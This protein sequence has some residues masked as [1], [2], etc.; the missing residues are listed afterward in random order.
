MNQMLGPMTRERVDELLKAYMP[1]KHT[2]ADIECEFDAVNKP[3]AI[4]QPGD[5]ERVTTLNLKH[6][7]LTLDHLMPRPF[8]EGDI[9]VRG[10]YPA[11]TIFKLDRNDFFAGV[12]RHDNIR[13]ATEEEKAVYHS[14][15]ATA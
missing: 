10:V 7:L 12:M 11:M 4:K 8:K 14:W 9:C 6:A 1:C 13:H 2:F 3:G 5:R 15:D